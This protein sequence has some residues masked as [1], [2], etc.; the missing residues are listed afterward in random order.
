VSPAEG[1]NSSMNEPRDDGLA[2]PVGRYDHALGPANA[3]VRLVEYGD[4]ECPYCRSA[5]LVLRKLRHRL[6]DRLRYVFRN[7]P[8]EAV[9]PHART[10]AEAAEA[11]AS[12]GRFWEM[13][14]RLFEH[15]RAR[16]D[17]DLLRHAAEL[18]LDVARFEGEMAEHAHAGKVEADYDGGLRSG[19]RATP[20]F[21]V[22]GA[23]HWGS[24]RTHSL[25]A[26]IEAESPGSAGRWRWPTA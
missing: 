15:Q 9:Y 11:A 18:G 5:Y 25:L 24:Y 23:R 1:G 20:T 2:V 4:Y 17:A 14:E 16:E 10:A 3:P 22:N 12:Q 13:H 8:L 19:V 7:F 26:A 21:F 6:G